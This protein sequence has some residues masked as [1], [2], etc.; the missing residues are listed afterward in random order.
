MVDLF[1][2]IRNNKIDEFKQVIHQ[3][4][5]EITIEAK[6]DIIAHFDGES[7]NAGRKINI[8]NFFKF[9]V[10]FYK[11]RDLTQRRTSTTR[12]QSELSPCIH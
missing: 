3:H 12:W 6:D 5:K 7:I 10:D 2:L 8:N 9:S 4:V 1:D 11:G